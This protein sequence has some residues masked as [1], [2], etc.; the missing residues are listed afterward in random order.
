MA[1]STADLR[2][3]AGTLTDIAGEL[4]RM[5]AQAEPPIAAEV[6]FDSWYA[7]RAAQL[8]HSSEQDD[9]EAALAAG[10]TVSRQAVREA[11]ERLAPEH[12]KRPGRRPVLMSISR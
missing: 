3:L 7:R 1:M 8:E 12:W 6:A 5:A 10:F 11:R 9:R 2:R 4:L